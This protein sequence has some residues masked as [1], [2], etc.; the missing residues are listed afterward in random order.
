MKLKSLR[1]VTSVALAFSA[2]V[3][4]PTTPANADIVSI[5]KTFSGFE[6]EKTAVTPDMKAAIQAWIAVNSDF[7]QVSCFG[8]TGYNVFNRS[9][10]FLQKLAVN[11]AQAVCRF[12][13]KIDSK[14]KIKSTGG[15]PSTSKNPS[16][17][18]VTITLTRTGIIQ[19]GGSG[20][21][22]GTGVIGTCDDKIIVK[23]KSRL[24]HA[25]LYF[26][27]INMSD[28]SNNCKGKYLDVYFTD[29][30]GAELAHA[31]NKPVAGATLSLLWSDFSTLEILSTTVDKVAISLH[32]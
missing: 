1:V 21:G 16:S 10:A 13:T 30:A 15:I 19:P 18:R 27:Q 11:R 26:S 3:T 31:L 24:L 23:M 22:S 2:L 32:D 7:T 28:I 6:F 4:A 29:A 5:S 25:G 20:D 9:K 17:R 8:Y 12:V 14:A